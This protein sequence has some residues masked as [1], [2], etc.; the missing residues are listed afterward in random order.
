MSEDR[1]KPLIQTYGPDDKGYLLAT[2]TCP[3]CKDIVDSG[4]V[5]GT[6]PKAVQRDRTMRPDARRVAQ[7][8]CTRGVAIAAAHKAYADHVC[9]VPEPTPVA[10]VPQSGQEA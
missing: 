2:A 3:A 1:A 10:E 7:T 5:V 8:E 9:A 4:W 6:L